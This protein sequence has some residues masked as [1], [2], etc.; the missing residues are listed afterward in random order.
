VG[1]T[2]F[3][4]T[5]LGACR[6]AA[7]LDDT[8]RFVVATLAND[9]GTFSTVSSIDAEKVEMLEACLERLAAD[10]VRRALVLATL[11]T[12]LTVGSSL[13]RRQALADEALSIARAHGDDATLVRVIN[14]VLLPLSVPHLLEVSTAR[15]VEG[16]ALAES[17]GDPNLLC[18]AVS[19]RRLLAGAS[20]DIEE[21][22]R[23]FELKDRL[24]AQIDLPFL[25][26]VHTVQRATRALIAGDAGLGEELA[27]RALQLG[28]DGG[29]PDAAMGFGIQLIMVH[30]L[31]GTLGTLIPL[32]EQTVADNPGLPVFSAVLALAHAEAD[33]DA[34]VRELLEGFARARYELPLDVAWLTAMIAWAETATACG[35]PRF[36]EPVLGQLAPFSDQWLYTDVTTAGPVSRPVGDLL[37]VLG[38]YDEA[39]RAF[40]SAHI[41]CEQADAVFFRAQTDLSWGRMLARRQAPGDTTRARDLLSR[42]RHAGATHGYEVV[43]RRAAK[44]LGRLN[45]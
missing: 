44:E 41:S 8:D 2:D 22:D 16:L 28:N 45:D 19:G 37:T 5:L 21:M 24:V 23:C 33:H 14:H 32:I 31:R 38:R 10:D 39:E 15:A 7:Q 13:E 27:L 42:A 35:D 30:L 40:E 34:E 11:C 6:E 36:A 4:E 43:E 9:R 3:R 18:T 1:D 17:V 25:N 26:W 29:Q 20:G 12:E